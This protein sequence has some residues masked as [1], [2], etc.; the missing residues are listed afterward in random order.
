V[1]EIH[2]LLQELPSTDEGDEELTNLD[3]LLTHMNTHHTLEKSACFDLD[4]EQLQGFLSAI[5]CRT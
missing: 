2:R 5:V 3:D 1:D 4:P